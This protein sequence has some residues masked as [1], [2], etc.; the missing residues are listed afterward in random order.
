MT[1]IPKK[2]LLA[3]IF[4]FI[5]TLSGCTPDIQH[6]IARF[7][8]ENNKIAVIKIDSIKQFTA[9]TAQDSIT[10]LQYNY[11]S[12]YRKKL[13]N[14]NN[15]LQ[16]LSGEIDKAQKELKTITNGR[17]YKIYKKAIDRLILKKQKIE[18][19]IFIYKNDIEQTSFNNYLN[20]INIY[21]EQPDSIIGFIL[22]V[23][24]TGKENLL[25]ANIYKKTYL[26][27]TSKTK[28]KGVI[29]E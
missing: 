16:E 3:Y 8:F 28:I 14:L 17:M 23:V 12:L 19:I 20:K 7:E 26:F 21:S 18:K 6:K 10:V 1:F 29:S 24:F 9:F 27:D 13:Y 15:Q 4:L 2:L 22:P 25:P 5:I 11:D